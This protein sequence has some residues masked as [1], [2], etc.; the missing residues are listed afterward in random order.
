PPAEVAREVLA[1]G[2]CRAE[3]GPEGSAQARRSGSA[4][5]GDGTW[6]RCRPEGDD[7]IERSGSPRLGDGTWPV[8]TGRGGRRPPDRDM[9]SGSPRLGDGTWPRCRPEGDD[10]IERGDHL[11]DRHLRQRRVELGAPRVAGAVPVPED[12]V[13][14]SRRR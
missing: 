4:R 14:W 13:V 10:V 11:V 1:R 6:P 5:P 3:W 7:V 12:D 8:W 9:G 2:A